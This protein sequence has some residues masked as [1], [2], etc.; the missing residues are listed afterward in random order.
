[1]AVG[2]MEAAEA[3]FIWNR[4]TVPKVLKI[5]ST[6]LPQRDLVSLLLVSPWL[7]R[8]LVSY[9]SIWLVISRLLVFFFFFFVLLQFF[10]YNENCIGLCALVFA[11]QSLDF[12]E[13]G[14]AGNRLVA[15][16]SLVRV[17]F[18]CKRLLLFCFYCQISMNDGHC[19]VEWNN[20]NNLFGHLR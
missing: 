17:N 1:M 4:E 11:S 5:V 13:M 16:L 8:S 12:S 18:D 6:R 19:R 7:Y 3:E 14:N 2:K 9:P 15:A 10:I 20:I